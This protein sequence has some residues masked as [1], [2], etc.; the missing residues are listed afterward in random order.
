MCVLLVCLGLFCFVCNVFVSVCYVGCPV[1]YWSTAQVSQVAVLWA[2][3]R[4]LFET[5]LFFVAL[6]FEEAELNTS[7]PR[8][9]LWWTHAF[10]IVLACL[11]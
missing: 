4:N 9:S 5:F 8:S 10:G 7:S 11:G 2:L 1:L 3:G 6:I